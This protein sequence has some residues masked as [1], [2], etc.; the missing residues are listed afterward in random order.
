MQIPRLL[1]DQRAIVTGAAR[2]IGRAIATTLAQSGATVLI[3]DLDGEQA[4]RTADELR[5]Q[6]LRAVATTVDVTREDSVRDMV[7]AA[8]RELGGLDVLVN[9]AGIYPT[10]SIEGMTVAEW[11]RVLAVDLR[12]VY[13]CSQAVMHHLMAQRSGAIVNIA[14]VDAFQPKPSKIHYAAAKTGV[15][16]LTRSFADELGRHGVRVN[17]VAPGL[18]ETRFAAALFQDRTA[19]EG[20]VGR[21]PLGRHGQ[22]ED[23]CGAVVFLASEAAAYMSG[24]VLIV[25]GGGRVG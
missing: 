4:R 18:I 25:D 15:L 19:Y 12:S 3:A 6:D 10:L 22:P 11:D 5:Q 13:L 8:L 24:Q 16:S 20:V 14:T 21:T 7:A 1:D 23:V 2:G 17:A 9:N